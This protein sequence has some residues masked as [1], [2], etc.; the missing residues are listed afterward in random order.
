[1]AR[2]KLNAGAHAATKLRARATALQAV[3][4]AIANDR[5]EFKTLFGL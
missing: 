4:A 2:L 1:M 5:S 3:H